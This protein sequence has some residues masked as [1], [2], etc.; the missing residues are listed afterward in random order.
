MTQ[1]ITR[2]FLITCATAAPLL[3]ANDDGL[4]R[5]APPKRDHPYPRLAP[6]D[7]RPPA[8]LT[9]QTIDG[10]FESYKP[11]APANQTPDAEGKGTIFGAG[12]YQRQGPD[13]GMCILVPGGNGPTIGFEEKNIPLKP[14]AWYRI[15]Y[16]IRGIPYMMQFSYPR[17]APV[18]G[19]GDT[20]KNII[21]IDN[22]FGGGYG[23]CYVCSE[24]QFVKM[25]GEADGSWITFGFRELP[26]KCPACDADGSALYREGSRQAYPE[27]KLVYAD[28]R[29]H[30][31]TGYFHNV[32]YYWLLVV[33]GS[34]SDTRL[35]NLMVYEITGEGGEPVGNDL[36][37]DIPANDPLTPPR[38][39][40]LEIIL[41]E[42]M[43]DR[44]MRAAS[45]EFQKSR[46]LVAAEKGIPIPA[47]RITKRPEVETAAILI[48]GQTIWNGEADPAA[49]GAALADALR[50]NAQ[51]LLTLDDTVLL[52]DAAR[53][54]GRTLDKPLP[55]IHNALRDILASGASIHPFPE[56]P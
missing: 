54:S 14:N 19:E 47:T 21:H 48:N 12:S 6:R 28:F 55:E 15:E 36:V 31:Y 32:P 17:E 51:H 41:P 22:N 44:T 18:P 2:A 52:V 42:S 16:M 43:A 23:F 40:A 27:W 3:H 34:G 7:P 8:R 4:W 56:L 33:I 26:E 20:Y 29:T 24:C 11:G 1:R 30:D 49:L 10:T 45:A 35:A 46:R 39:S 38:V 5:P 50:A 25:G 37:T 13:G 9:S 53:K